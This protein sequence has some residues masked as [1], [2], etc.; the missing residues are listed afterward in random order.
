MSRWKILRGFATVYG[1][2]AVILVGDGLIREW[3]HPIEVVM[4]LTLATIGG[5]IGI[6]YAARRQ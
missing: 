1:I 6:V 5:V 3:R 2:V 4:F